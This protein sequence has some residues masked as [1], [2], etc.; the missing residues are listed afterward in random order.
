MLLT[1]Y[2][3]GWGQADWNLKRIMIHNVPVRVPGTAVLFDDGI[4]LRYKSVMLKRFLSNHHRYE[5]EN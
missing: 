3:R 2:D 5:A 4:K 1:W